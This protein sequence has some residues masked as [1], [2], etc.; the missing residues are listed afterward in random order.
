MLILYFV[1]TSSLQCSL[2]SQR[3]AHQL[4]VSSSLPLPPEVL[5]AQH[6]EVKLTHNSS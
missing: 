2:I 5:L 1:V 6:F 4:T 3:A